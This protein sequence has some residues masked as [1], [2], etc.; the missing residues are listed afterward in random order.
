MNVRCE[1]GGSQGLH[2]G[3]GVWGSDLDP[4]YVMCGSGLDL[5]VRSFL[6]AAQCLFASAG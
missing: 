3:F 6:W 2:L 4:W 1:C 5:G